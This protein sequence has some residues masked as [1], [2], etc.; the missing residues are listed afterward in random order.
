MA[1][2][3]EKID[4]P[5]R[6]M[7]CANCALTVERSLKKKVK[8]L[9]SAHVNLATE[10]ASLEFDPRQTGLEEISEVV[11]WAGYHAELPDRLDEEA[12]ERKTEKS[13]QRLGF[14]V[15][16]CFTLPLFFLSM[17]RDF[18]ILGHWS[19]ADWMNWLFL[20]LATPVQF[21]TGRG[22]YAGAYRSFVTK[23]ANMD[24]LVAL[25]S[26]VAYFYSLIILVIPL[27]AH[28]SGIGNHVYFETSAMIITL[29]KLGKLLEANAK[30]RTSAA[31]RK[32]M[33]LAPRIAHLLKNGKHETDIP[34]DQ[35]RTDDLI[36]V[37]PGEAIP[38]DGTVIS[39]ISSVDESMLTGESIPA[40]KKE[41][42]RVFGAT[43]NQEGLMKIRATHVG[44]ETAI[45]RI[46]RLVREAQG[47]KAPIQR[48]ADRVAA[49]F[50][51]VILLIASLTF[52]L[53]WTFGGVFVTAMLRMVAVLVIACPCALGLATPTAIMVGTGTGARMGILFRSAEALET[54]HKLTTVM[55]D[56][57]GTITEGKPVLTGWEPVE[58]TDDWP[59]MAA[60]A[61]QGSEHPLARA[62]VVGVKKSGLHLSE[63]ENFRNHPGF[64]VEARIKGKTVRVGKP[65]WFD[66]K[67]KIQKT[68]KEL[69]RQGNT[70]VMVEIEGKIAGL[71]TIADREKASSKEAVAALKILGLKPVMLTGDNEYTAKAVASRVGIDRVIFGILPD[72]KESFVR[73]AQ[74]NREVVA[75]V[76]D[77]INDAPALA[78]AD[79][80]IAIGSG[81]DIALEASDITLV[82]N[83][84]RDVG[85]AIGLSNATMKTIKQNLFWAFFY[86]VALI[87]LAA[88]FFS[89]IG[90]FPGFILH[91][92]LAAGAMAFSSVTVVFNSLRLARKKI[93]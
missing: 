32:L 85:R 30:G 3:T 15:G 64:G 79:V 18:G 16:V 50:V 71:M 48:L 40:D 60:S 76:G 41:S 61:E 89:A 17:S 23:S 63:P 24:L 35:V 20:A 44:S 53:W 37:K 92:A 83:D 77:G 38:V 36:L 49:I 13:R 43:I 14:W 12:E 90:L 80:G 52:I 59:A 39:G 11:E 65:D 42:D 56:K 81:T 67:P 54:A 21:F 73:Q 22:F 82:K 46:I 88:G 9:M 33:D 26:S 87:P 6:G 75:M 8:G 7:T 84:L 28:Q 2:K 51:P 25:G 1:K 19:H 55:F 5:I 86:N 68:A 10:I 93:K 91:P 27:F 31:I 62:I 69:A 66:L 72:Q 58:P 74:A 78:R 34:A 45:A 47:S 57:T 70:I 4:I 29:I